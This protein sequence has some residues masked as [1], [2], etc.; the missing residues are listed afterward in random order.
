[1]EGIC[2]EYYNVQSVL[3]RQKETDSNFDKRGPCTLFFPPNILSITLDLS[4][5]VAYVLSGINE[6]L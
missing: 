4:C 1:M 5:N 6:H 2:N 3:L